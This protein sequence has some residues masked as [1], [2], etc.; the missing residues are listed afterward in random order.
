MVSNRSARPPNPRAPLGLLGKVRLLWEVWT[1]AA[2]VVIGLRRERL[3]AL[4]ARM[5]KPEGR[6]PKPPTLLSRAVSRGLR[7]GPWKPRCLIRALVLYRL[8]RSQGDNAVLVIGLADARPSTEAHAWVELGGRDVG[9]A[10]GA[11]GHRALVRYPIDAVEHDC[12][13]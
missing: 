3:P 11:N 1:T 10:P 2:A 13:A 9:P 12:T 6:Q 4:V 7:L 5:G 8:L